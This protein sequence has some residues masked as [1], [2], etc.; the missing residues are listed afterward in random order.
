MPRAGF[1]SGWILFAGLLMLLIG[2]FNV[3]QGLAAILSESYYV[4][5]EDELLVFDFTAWG[6]ITLVW[7][8]ALVAGGV[9][10]VTGRE[11]ARWTGIAIVGLNAVAQAAFLAA[12][13]FWSV[14]VIALCV[15]VLF[16]LAARWEVA[17]DDM[18]GTVSGGAG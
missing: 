5:T 17:Q 2:A 15:L 6:W 12:F 16:A 18:R 11:W 9:G 4:V 13:P 7:G 3:L 10:L 1:W 8:I 14:L